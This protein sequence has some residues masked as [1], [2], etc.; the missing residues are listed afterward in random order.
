MCYSVGELI[1]PSPAQ[2]QSPLLQEGPTPGKGLHLAH[3]GTG[4]SALAFQRF[5]PIA[6]DTLPQDV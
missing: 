2:S 1:F 5:F 6:L 3:L 4:S